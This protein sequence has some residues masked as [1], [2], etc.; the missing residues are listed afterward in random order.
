MLIGV[1]EIGDEA[2]RLLVAHVSDGSLSPVLTRRWAGMP[3]MKTWNR[4]VADVIESDLWYV[5]DAGAESILVCAPLT[6][7]G[8]P[9]ERALRLA[10]SRAG[11]PAPR[12]MTP[13][14]RASLAF[15]GATATADGLPDTVAVIDLGG[16]STKVATGRPGLS[17]AWLGSRAVGAARLNKN[18]LLSDPPSPDQL[19]AARNAIARRLMRLEPP[20]CDAVLVAAGDS[21]LEAV[22]GAELDGKTIGATLD[23]FLL[24]GSSG[25]GDGTVD[26]SLLR[27]LPAELLVLEALGDLLPQPFRIASGGVLEGLALSVTEES[28]A[29]A[30]RNG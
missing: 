13:G 7:R 26:A 8:T 6:L 23:R 21:A 30:G 5:R 16:D 24:L 14:D 10:C 29:A 15:A 9:G 11:A 19:A 18:A 3:E 20:A 27:S 22:C 2:T 25:L 1:I 4:D 17:P 12:L 28:P